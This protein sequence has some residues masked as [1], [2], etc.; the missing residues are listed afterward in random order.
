MAEGGEILGDR[1]RQWMQGCIGD[2]RAQLRGQ[3]QSIAH[4]R[5]ITRTATPERQARQGAFHVW[6]SR[7]KPAQSIARRRD[8]DK[9]LHRIE[10]LDDCRNI[11]E[12]ALK[13]SAIVRAPAP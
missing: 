12:R 13:R 4:R 9:E 7:Q 2:N 5:E 10:P 3:R 6:T 1:F 8:G 11:G